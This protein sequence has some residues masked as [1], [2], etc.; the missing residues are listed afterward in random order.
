MRI[1]ICRDCRYG[2]GRVR[3]RRKGRGTRQRGVQIQVARADG[4]EVV[5]NREGL[6]DRGVGDDGSG[7]EVLG[8]GQH[9]ASFH[10]IGRQVLTSDQG[11][12]R[13][14]G[15]AGGHAGPAQYEV[16]GTSTRGRVLHVGSQRHLA[17]G[18][19]SFKGGSGS[20]NREYF[21]T[22]RDQIRFCHKVDQRRPFRAVSGHQVVGAGGGAL[23][24]HGS[25]GEHERIIAGRGDGPV[26][27]GVR[28]IVAPAVARGND[29]GD[30]GKPC[31]LHFL[32]ERIVSI[33][34]ENRAAK[35][36]VDDFDVVNRA[37]LNGAFDRLNHFRVVRLAV[38]VQNFEADQMSAGSHAVDVVKVGRTV[39]IGAVPGD[40]ARHVRAVTIIIVD[41]FARDKAF[42]VGDVR[43]Q[44]GQAEGIR[45][46]AGEVLIDMDS[47]IDQGD[48]NARPQIRIGGAAGG[49]CRLDGFGH[50][51][52]NGHRGAHAEEWIVDRNVGDRRILR[53]AERA[54]HGCGTKFAARQQFDQIQRATHRRKQRA[55]ERRS[56]LND[57]LDRLVRWHR[58]QLWRNGAAQR[59]CGRYQQQRQRSC[60]SDLHTF[61][62]ALGSGMRNYSERNQ[63]GAPWELLR[64]SR[65][66]RVLVPAGFSGRHDLSLR[67]NGRRVKYRFGLLG[68]WM[69]LVIA[70]KANEWERRIS[71]RVNRAPGCTMRNSR[72]R[73]AL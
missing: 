52:V 59:D 16:A 19:R 45:A 49:R 8:G 5:L 2:R 48:A 51:V 63:I 55:H 11:R 17:A 35:R 71:P 20:K 24:I 47:A 57:D 42:G 50:V 30:A 4:E 29:H 73:L 61:H 68:P 53:E 66:N 70:P 58:A 14:A 27:V 56:V 44:V 38:A 37:Q 1:G 22:G 69:R 28:Q 15:Y 39:R 10:L 7:R 18:F 60:K 54:G 72:P 26:A 33:T 65:T 9:Q 3:A 46:I 36:K 62:Q 31:F 41:A 64:V 13:A 32:A 12:G 67:G 40:N 25:D 6:I 34:L 21:I 23:G 43:E